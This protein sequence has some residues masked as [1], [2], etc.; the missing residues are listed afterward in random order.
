MVTAA[1]T[2]LEYGAQA[3]SPTWELRSNMKRGLVESL[4]QIFTIH[5]EAQVM[6]MFGMNVFH[7]MLYTGVLWA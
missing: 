4:S 3:T 1:K 6:K 2:V 5:S 7:W